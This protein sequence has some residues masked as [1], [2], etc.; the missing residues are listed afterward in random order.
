MTINIDLN[1]IFESICQSMV[2]DILDQYLFY[3][4]NISRSKITVKNGN[5]N[6]NFI[7]LKFE[8]NKHNAYTNSNTEMQLSHRTSRAKNLIIFGI[9]GNHD[10]FDNCKQDEVNIRKLI[11][12]LRVDL[13]DSDIIECKRLETK[14]S[15]LKE[16]PILIR[17]ARYETKRDI[18]KHAK[19]LRHS[20]EFKNVAITPDYSA[21]KRLA[22]KVLIQT[23]IDLNKQLKNRSPNAN[24]YFSI[25]KQ[26]II[27]HM[28]M[29]REF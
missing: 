2:E 25:K 1:K 4:E 23:K 17:L 9:Q 7:N 28:I 22:I 11:A 13:D 24:Y 8:I 26:T 29:L 12:S 16:K 14:K 20:S 19:E 3:E 5:E 15:H 6:F 27:Q 10:N 18:L 21:K